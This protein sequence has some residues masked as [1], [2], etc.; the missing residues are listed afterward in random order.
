MWFVYVSLNLNLISTLSINTFPPLHPPSTLPWSVES[1]TSYQF[2]ILPS[3]P[4]NPSPSNLPSSNT[5]VPWVLERIWRWS[6]S[7]RASPSQPLPSPP[8][9]YSQHRGGIA[10]EPLSFACKEHHIKSQHD[11]NHIH[12]YRLSTSHLDNEADINW[13]GADQAW[14]SY[15][16]C[17]SL[18]LGF[19][20]D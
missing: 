13:I 10:T 19:I 14:P 16:G 2:T 3:L 9:A 4:F 15:S 17:C 12:T 20:E 6:P 18:L 1:G 5:F 8:L 11:Y 7:S